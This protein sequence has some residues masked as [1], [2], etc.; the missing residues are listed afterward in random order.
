MLALSKEPCLLPQKVDSP[1]SRLHLPDSNGYS[2]LFYHYSITILYAILCAILSLMSYMRPKGMNCLI[3]LETERTLR[4]A[5]S[6]SLPSIL[7][8]KDSRMPESM[9]NMASA[10]TS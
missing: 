3:L 5:R 10:S 8:V 9:P 6:D 7:S 4:R 1:S 2:I